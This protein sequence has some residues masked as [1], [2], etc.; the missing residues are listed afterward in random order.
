MAN[1]YRGMINAK[2]CAEG[3]ICMEAETPPKG[4]MVML[5]DGKG[6]AA[7]LYYSVASATV[8][9]A[10]YAVEI[11]Y[12]AGHKEAA[13]WLRKNANFLGALITWR[14]A[15]IYVRRLRTPPPDNTEVESMPEGFVVRFKKAQ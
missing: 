14:E 7:T 15:Q 2:E 6:K 11:L 8:T 13:E 4:F 9:K 3:Y 12:M 5:K 10:R 1:F